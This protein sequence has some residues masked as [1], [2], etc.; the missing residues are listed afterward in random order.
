MKLAVV[1][2]G[3][4]GLVAAY[5]LNCEHHVTVYEANDYAG[6]HT[7]TQ[8]VALGRRRYAVD[9]G[10]I[11]FNERTYPNFVRLLDRLGVTSQ[12]SDMSFSV[13][14]ARTGMEY[15]GS[16]LSALFAQRR[17]VV[18]LAFLRM[19]FDIVR[20]N[21]KARTVLRNGGTRQTLREFF[22]AQGYS[23]Y[24]QDYYIVPMIAA[25]WS[26]EPD[27]VGD[28]P[29]QQFFQF[30]DNHGLLNLRDHVEWRVITGGSQR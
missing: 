10:F 18:R 11:V 13:A 1:G 9:T 25:I 8:T 2:T 6:G 16:S 3:I 21:N 19:L 12:P 17:N 27:T 15:A 28:L 29:A 4:S 26:A 23:R 24:F 5:L 14:C 7:N 30:F 20:F 22:A